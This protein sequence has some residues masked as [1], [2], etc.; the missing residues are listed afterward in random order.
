MLILT[1]QPSQPAILPTGRILT[2][3]CRSPTLTSGRF[4][5]TIQIALGHCQNDAESE[6][7]MFHYLTNLL[8]ILAV[9]VPTVPAVGDCGCGD[10]AVEVEQCCGDNCTCGDNCQCGQATETTPGQQ[11]T[12]PDSRA[13]DKLVQLI[14]CGQVCV[15]ATPP[16]E[17]DLPPD[18]SPR[19]PLS[20]Q[21]IC[22]RLNRFLL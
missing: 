19:S 20:A 9:A 3:N 4:R 5:R 18:T 13:F 12:T 17:H 6:R 15:S 10:I 11:T 14:H 16:A 22:A 1:L 2:R 21:Q 7:G 8:L